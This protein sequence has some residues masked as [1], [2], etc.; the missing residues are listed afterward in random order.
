MKRKAPELEWFGQKQASLNEEYVR[1]LESLQF[2]VEVQGRRSFISEDNFLAR[3]LPKKYLEDFHTTSLVYYL[4]HGA[5]TD[6]EHLLLDRFLQVV[7]R[8]TPKLDKLMPNFIRGIEIEQE[9]KSDGW[10]DILIFNLRTKQAIIVENK[11]WAIDQARQLPRYYWELTEQGEYEVLAV[12]YLSADGHPPYTGDWTDHDLNA[13]RPVTIS[14]ETLL[15][16]WLRPARRE[17]KLTSIHTFLSW[18]SQIIEHL[19]EV[20]T[21]TNMLKDFAAGLAAN[22]QSMK[23]I[24]DVFTQR[25]A[26]QRALC[27]RLY[28]TMAPAAKEIE[29]CESAVRED[30]EARYIEFDCVDR[31]TYVLSYEEDQYSYGFYFKG[32]HSN[33]KERDA[34]K[35]ILGDDAEVWTT[36]GFDTVFVYS[37][38]MDLS[39]PEL[40]QVFQQ[41]WIEHEIERVRSHIRRAVE[42]FDQE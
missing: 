21:M 39:D 38:K 10:I 2:P 6:S 1:S 31:V 40:H 42:V 23:A 24:A 27:I 19:L 36:N 15:E 11:V 14:Y 35:T 37:C 30:G 16:E 17:P 20:Q 41:P 7:A 32:R 18:Y 34:C 12:V 26:L 29:E 28:E 9:A 8:R 13:I 22:P 5:G 3:L 33:K 25:E 4:V